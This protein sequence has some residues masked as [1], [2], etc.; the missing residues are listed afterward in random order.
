MREKFYANF[1]INITF[2]L[3]LSYVQEVQNVSLVAAKRAECY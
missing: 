2:E 3:A 1:Y